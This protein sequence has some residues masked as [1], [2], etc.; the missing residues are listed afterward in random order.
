[1]PDIPDKGVM[2]DVP[3]SDFVKNDIPAETD[4]LQLG[5]RSPDAQGGKSGVAP[6]G[7]LRGTGGAAAERSG[8]GS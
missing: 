4:D 8:D 7:K 5:Q 2:P 3:A 6:A 1:M